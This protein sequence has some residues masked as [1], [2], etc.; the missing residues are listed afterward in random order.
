MR[1][2]ALSALLCS[3]LVIPAITLAASPMKP[4]LWEVIVQSDAMKQTPQISPE[5]AAQIR[6]MGIK[7][8]EFRNG[9][10]VT[11]VCYTKAMLAR[12]E[13]PG[14][15]QQNRECKTQNM[16]HEGNNFSAEYV[17][18]GR[19]MKGTGTASGTM[20]DTN[21]QIKSTFNG[22]VSGYATNQSSTING[23][24]VSDNCGK[25]KPLRTP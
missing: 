23:T 14:Q 13:V 10:M 1:E 20:T 6:K 9:G 5:Q 15:G 7:V 8:P 22:T 21:F 16:K 2:T 25:V 11:Q 4:G 12:D 3:L 17:C 24:F 19:N 18:D